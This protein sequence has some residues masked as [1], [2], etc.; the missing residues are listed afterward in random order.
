M[1]VDRMGRSTVAA[2]L[3]LGARN[4]DD[5][6]DTLHDIL[7]VD[8]G[9]L[10]VDRT[11]YWSLGTTPPSITCELG[12]VRSSP[13]GE[14][15]E[16]GM[17][18]L[19]R[20]SPRYFKELRTHQALAIA[21]TA[22]DERMRGMESYL[23]RQGVKALLDVPV[24]LRGQQVGVLCHEHVGSARSWS[25]HDMEFALACSQAVT[26]ALEAR[27]RSRAEEAERRAKFLVETAT[28]LAE[29]FTH[30]RPA[31][32]AA[33]HATHE[34][35][36]VVR[37][38]ER[39]G[40]VLVA[41]ATVHRRPELQAIAERLSSEPIPLESRR[42]AARTVREHQSLLVPECDRTGLFA[43]A[44]EHHRRLIEELKIRSTMAVPLRARGRV[45]GVLVCASATRSYEARDLR[46]AEAFAREVAVT[47]DNVRLYQRAQ[48]AVFARDEFLRLASH[49]LRTPLAALLLSAEGLARAVDQR[50]YDAVPRLSDAIRRQAGRLQ[51]LTARM[52]DASEIGAGPLSIRPET[53]DLVELV[54][55]IA[56]TFIRT[57]QSRGSRL[58]LDT[59]PAVVG[60]WDPTRLEQVVNNLLDNAIKFGAG[61][62]IDVGVHATDGHARLVV[63]DH[64][65]G[66]SP[67][68]AADLFE[69]YRRG[70]DARSFGGLGLGLHIVREITEAHGGLVAVHPVPGGGAE[71]TVEL[72]LVTP[73][74]KGGRRDERPAP[75]RRG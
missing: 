15:Y 47:M 63:R 74:A 27:M 38:Y 22:V 20:D 45:V 37:V 17:M 19:E 57:A 11:S 70:V 9:V 7:K 49:E 73:G 60:W 50:A 54:R 59:D 55:E 14:T 25:E 1:S 56:D 65:I 67:R 24:Y 69:R 48:A 8:A 16:R 61:H 4:N 53:V 39:V 3:Q 32:T 31:Q 10:D 23:Q 33:L 34:L 18:L 46:L 66:V 36:D 5:W 71:F 28:L 2:L 62:P 42:L 13:A 21:D 44:D 64:G 40:D 75:S 12:L 68:S 72:P 6:E 52:L 41:R 58:A 30:E 43:D 29:D 51:R 35:G 26:A